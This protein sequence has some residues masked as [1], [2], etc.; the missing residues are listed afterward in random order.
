MTSAIDVYGFGVVLLELFSGRT[1]AD[2]DEAGDI[3]HITDLTV[4]LITRGDFEAAL[5]PNMLKPKKIEMASIVDMACLAVECESITTKDRPLMSEV[6]S[7]LSGAL[8]RLSS[9][10]TNH[11]DEEEYADGR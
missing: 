5:D 11:V 6:L 4:P 8:A 3:H 2:R 9:N 7:H 1:P 10:E